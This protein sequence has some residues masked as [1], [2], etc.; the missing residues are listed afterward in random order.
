MEKEWEYFYS[1]ARKYLE[2]ARNSKGDLRENYLGTAKSF[3]NVLKTN[4]NIYS[5]KLEKQNL[6]NKKSD[7]EILSIEINNEFSFN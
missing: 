7:L 5:K 6:E 3:E 2:R 1:G 4:L